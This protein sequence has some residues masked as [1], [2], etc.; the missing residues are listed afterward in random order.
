MSPRRS[1]YWEYLL[2]FFCF[3]VTSC[4]ERSTPL[5][6]PDGVV[7]S[8]A[9]GFTVK[10]S[11]Q[12]TVLY[13][14]TSPRI[15]I[16][17][18]NGCNSSND[19]LLY[20]PTVPQRIICLSTTHIAFLEALGVRESIVGVS[21]GKFVTSPFLRKAIQSSKVVD[22]GQISNLDIEAIISLQPD[23]VLGYSTSDHLPEY[24]HY[25]RRLSI[26][27]LLCNEYLEFHPLGRSEW[28]KF[29]GYLLRRGELANKLFDSINFL[30]GEL[31][32]RTRNPS[33]RPS[34][35]LNYPW[36][37]V[38]YIP[39]DS[40]YMSQ[41]IR[42]AGGINIIGNQFLDTKSHSC[43]IEEVIK[44]GVN[45]D[46]WL[47][48]ST[49]DSLSDLKQYRNFQSVLK[50]QVYNNTLRCKIGYGNDFYESGVLLPHLILRD[51]QHILHPELCDTTPSFFF[52]KKLF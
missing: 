28:I 25:L 11:L 34:V 9:K 36:K 47:H 35:L 17:L 12:D 18:K 48:P 33:Y 15:T 42:D 29:L 40:S 21:E 13:V 6:Y 43:A 31:Y 2:L 39:G 32:L 26:P 44:E 7:L 51:L 37:D 10:A 4:T 1:C 24:Y 20:I 19:T 8:Y 46:Y 45:A 5:Q 16:L 27:V 3:L 23:L 22:I 41:L 14:N 38:W 52:Y 30:Y 50:K 49:I